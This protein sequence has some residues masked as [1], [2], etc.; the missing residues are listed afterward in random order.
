VGVKIGALNSRDLKM[1]EKYRVKNGDHFALTKTSGGWRFTL[2]LA[3][4]GQII[5]SQNITVPFDQ[6]VDTIKE[7]YEVD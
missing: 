2:H 6:I 4:G 3:G 7:R 1:V 5:D